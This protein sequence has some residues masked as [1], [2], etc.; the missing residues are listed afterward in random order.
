MST[1]SAPPTIPADLR[2]AVAARTELGDAYEE[3]LT[4]SLLDR[5]DAQVE[6]RLSRRAASLAHEAVTVLVALGSIGLGVLVAL[7]SNGL[8]DFGGTIATIVAWIA[9]AVIN[10]AHARARDR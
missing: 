10:V 9:I 8:G 7:V 5:F 1:T 4:D 6:H 3:A 2:A